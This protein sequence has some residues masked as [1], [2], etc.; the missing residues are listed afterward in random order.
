[1]DVTI[2]VHGNGRGADSYRHAKFR[3]S[4]EGGEAG[5]DGE[6]RSFNNDLDESLVEDLCP[7]TSSAILSVARVSCPANWPEHSRQPHFPQHD[8]E[9]PY[10]KPTK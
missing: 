1:M 6:S 5:V 4:R 7:A 3:S 2:A 9:Y 8:I 10:H